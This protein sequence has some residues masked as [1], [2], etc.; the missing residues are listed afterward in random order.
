MAFLVKWF[1]NIQGKLKKSYNIKSIKHKK[2]SDSD[3]IWIQ[4]SWF[5]SDF[6]LKHNQF[7]STRNV[8]D[9][10]GRV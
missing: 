10:K 1:K 9:D 5:K 3:K 2:V 6:V 8:R 7:R 4:E